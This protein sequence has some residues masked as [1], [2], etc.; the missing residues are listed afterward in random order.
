MGKTA[1]R[2]ISC[3][4]AAALVLSASQGNAAPV[5]GQFNITVNLQTGGGGGGGG[6]GP[7][8]AFCVSHNAPG[9]FGATVTVVCSTGAF[10]DIS[11]SQARPPWTPTHGGS[12][13]YATQVFWNGDWLESLDDRLGT[14]TITSWR[15]VNLMNRNYLE[16]TVG[17]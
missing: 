12:F 2:A 5:S 3:A 17:W 9:S 8:S 14:G 4:L 10:V 16:M 1:N 6:S 7:G 15:V 13:R 11:P